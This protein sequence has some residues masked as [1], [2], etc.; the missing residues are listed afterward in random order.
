MIF[1][2]SVPSFKI[3]TSSILLAAILCT[4]LAFAE[5]EKLVEIRIDGNRRIESAAILNVI[6]VH[7]GDTLYNDKTDSD[8]RAIY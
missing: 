7:A 8:I 4:T 2:G 1:G 3:V 6:T 5:G